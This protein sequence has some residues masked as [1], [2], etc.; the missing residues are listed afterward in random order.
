M[1]IAVESLSESLQTAT[2]ETIP[3][4]T[5]MI[6]ASQNSINN[7]LEWL[8]SSN[9]LDNEWHENVTR[10][11]RLLQL[12]LIISRHLTLDLEERANIFENVFGVC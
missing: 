6:V 7:L 8:E 9:T 3:S 2:P 1:S 4:I 5:E 10:N 12:K 11:W